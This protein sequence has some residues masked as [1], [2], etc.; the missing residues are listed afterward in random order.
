MILVTGR[1]KMGGCEL[2]ELETH[3]RT[4][5]KAGDAFRAPTSAAG[6]AAPACHH[7]AR[8]NMP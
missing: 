7:A 6:L 2:A 8:K 5:Q 1:W 4:P 3:P